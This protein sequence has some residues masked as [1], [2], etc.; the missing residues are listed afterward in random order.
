[1]AENIRPYIIIN[2]KSSRDVSGLLIVSL[3]PITKPQM[4]VSAEEIDGRDGDI[5]TELGF[6][7]YD[8]PVEIGLAGDYDIN[9]VISYFNQAGI[10]TFSNEPDKYYRF[11]QYNGIDFEK[12]IRFKTA[13]VIFHVQPFKYATDENDAVFWN[14]EN[15]TIENEGNIY[16]KPELAIQGSGN[17]GIT[18]NG[19][20]VLSLD[21]GETQQAII[22]DTEKMNAYG[23][24]SNIKSLVADINPVQDLHGYDY[25]WT[26]G[27]GKNKL[28]LSDTA[29]TQYIEVEIDEIP[30]GDYVFSSVITSSDTDT[31]TCAI[32]F[33]D[34][35]K[36]TLVSRLMNRSVGGNRVST[37]ISVSSPIKYLRLYASAG[38][39]SGSG[40]DASFVD[41]M[42]CL[43]SAS[44]PTIYA[45]YEN[46]CPITGWDEV[47]VTHT[48]GEMSAPVSLDFGQTVYGGTIDLTT[49]LLR[50]THNGVKIRDNYWLYMADFKYFHTTISAIKR[51]TDAGKILEGL[52][53][54]A[55]AN[56]T[57]SQAGSGDI[58]GSIAGLRD[59]VRIK[60]LAYDNPTDFVNAMGDYL[61]VYPLETP[62][63]I[64][65]TAQEI[66]AFIGTNVIFADT[67]AI[68]ELIYTKD[69]SDIT[70]SG[71]S[72]SFDVDAS[73]LRDDILKNRLV[74]GNYDNLRLKAGS[75]QIGITGDV[76]VLVFS[77]FSRWL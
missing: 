10:I 25:P 41:N 69:G 77:N 4:R 61:I 52:M 72:V 73:D 18:L 58:N 14:P 40:D 39:P 57:P 15:I 1:M 45:P 43:Q 37:T 46:I 60:D 44:N 42:I 20:E 71:D 53:C 49:G 8:K 33:L 76:D 13:T 11:A 75:N 70:T 2:G 16:S 51:N 29:F 26:A 21:L 48:S 12:L 17:V 30:S 47:N 66:E 6:S 5:V 22:I 62:I 23:T 63:E 28:S 32:I 7:A 19:S 9:E 56:R 50:I 38:Y 24:K 34:A 65:L 68:S 59:S 55:Y 3:P 74:T 67:G 64:Q 31:D 27:G 54:E 35:N 36:N